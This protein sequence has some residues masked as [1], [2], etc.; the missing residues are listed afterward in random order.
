MNPNSWNAPIVRTLACACVMML[1]AHWVQAA[2]GDVYLDLEFGERMT[3]QAEIPLRLSGTAAAGDKIAIEYR[4]TTYS[5]V[6]DKTGHWSVDVEPGAAGGPF[7][8]R[9]AG[10]TTIELKEV[11]VAELLLNSVLGDG[12]VLQRGEKAPVF[13]TAHPGDAVNVSFRGKTYEAKAG[14]D[15][16]WRVDVAPGD[17]GGPFEMSVKG[18][19]ELNLKDIYVGEV[20]LC[21]GQSNMHYALSYSKD[22]A[23]LKLD[24]PNPKLRLQRFMESSYAPN[25][26]ALRFLGWQVA[27]R[28]S[29]PPFSGT[30]YYFGAALQEKLGV[31]VGL[32][33]S[34][35]NAT[36]IWEWSP[37]FE[38]AGVKNGKLAEGHLYKRQVKAMQPFAIRGAIW[39]QG[40]ANATAPKDPLGIGY[41]LRLSALIQGWRRD[42]GQGDFPFLFVQLARIGLASDQIHGKALP[43]P[44]QREVI[45]GWARVRDEQ[46]RALALVPHAAMSV[47]YD[48]TT[49]NLHPPEKKAIAERLALA[50]RA[51][52]YGEKI[53]GSG[54]LVSGAKIENGAVVLSFMHADGLTARDGA[55][56]QVD[57]AGADGHFAPAEASVTGATVRIKLPA[58][59]GPY[60]VRYAYREWPD[61]NLVNG[62]GLP[63]SPFEL[64]EI[65]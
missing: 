62:A 10:R 63:A 29:A 48:L 42:W 13:G 2:Q 38:I 24:Q 43:T 20:W 30:A 7:P 1:C 34:A 61:G 46:R 59:A 52:V 5:A 27:D 28:T 17:A 18:R 57:I 9:I 36:N 51:E 65:K 41:D 6:S 22:F 54:P 31:P 15:G 64:S 55:L 44:E 50:A 12:M 3:L 11:R 35:Y 8:M 60:V 58:S 49:G 37:A 39:Y 4:G 26:P 23:G 56:R 21:S 33:H 25:R 40:E 16:E 47:S 19:V 53:E 45:A 14:T 32:I